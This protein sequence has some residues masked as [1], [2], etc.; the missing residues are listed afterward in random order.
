MTKINSMRKKYS[1]NS[2]INYNKIKK[3]KKKNYNKKYNKSRKHIRKYKKTNKKKKYNRMHKK[4]ILGGASADSNTN[5]LYITGPS[6]SGKTH[7]LDKII[8]K[9][10]FEDFFYKGDEEDNYL[11]TLSLD[12]GIIRA[13]SN[14]YQ[15][16][17]ENYVNFGFKNQLN[18]YDELNKLEKNKLQGVYL[19]NIKKEVLSQLITDIKTIIN[20]GEI[21]YPPTKSQER[22]VYTTDYKKNKNIFKKKYNYEVNSK[23]FREK[24][25]FNSINIYKKNP[26][27]TKL[28]GPDDKKKK[29]NL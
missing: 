6:A 24:L 11:I 12:G 5:M 28:F 21:K 4:K 19:K 22:Y 23:D 8:T 16:V 3:S 20:K 1:G 17:V 15:Y 10:S 29:Q 2:K 27:I 25:M 18:V 14:V 13:K 9:G 7:I 26:K